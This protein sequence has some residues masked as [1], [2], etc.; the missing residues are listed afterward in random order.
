MSKN[1]YEAV[2]AP[3]NT[4]AEIAKAVEFR[5]KYYHECVIALGVAT[6]KLMELNIPIPEVLPESQDVL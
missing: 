3:T 2:K 6:S 5:L 1:R 4:E